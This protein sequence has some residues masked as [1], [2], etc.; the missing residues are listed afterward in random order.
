METGFLYPIRMGIVGWTLVIVVAE[1]FQNCLSND[2]F[3]YLDTGRKSYM[4]YLHNVWHS[5]KPQYRANDLSELP[6]HISYVILYSSGKSCSVFWNGMCSNVRC[7]WTLPIPLPNHTKQKCHLLCHLIT[8]NFQTCWDPSHIFV[9]TNKLSNH[10]ANYVARW[11][12]PKRKQVQN[13]L[14]FST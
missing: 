4:W 2:W 12:L 1:R 14:T 6:L 8:V 5:L 11:F 13:H 9:S 10:S 3:N 7:Q